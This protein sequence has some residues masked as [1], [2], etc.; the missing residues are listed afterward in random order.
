MSAQCNVYRYTSNNGLFPRVK[1]TVSVCGCVY[2]KE[3][4]QRVVRQACICSLLLNS[5]HIH[6]WPPQSHIRDTFVLCVLVSL[7]LSVTLTQ[8]HNLFALGKVNVQALRGG[9][10]NSRKCP[11]IHPSPGNSQTLAHFFRHHHKVKKNCSSH[12]LCFLLGVSGA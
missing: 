11:Q 6:L 7:S 2:I 5:L 1:E 9:L 4:W 8:T 3:K 12:P 10:E